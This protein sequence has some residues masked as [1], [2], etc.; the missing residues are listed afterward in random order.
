LK[1]AAVKRSFLILLALTSAMYLSGC[2]TFE[3]SV[4]GTKIETDRVNSISPG[5]TTRADILTTFGEPTEITTEGDI[6]KMVYTYAEK[7]VPVYM[8]LIKNEAR[9]QKTVTNLEII[10]RGDIVSNYRFESTT[11]E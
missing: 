5:T 9:A 4:T 11:E 1:E 7:K 2:T 3:T 6:E 8:E 10:L